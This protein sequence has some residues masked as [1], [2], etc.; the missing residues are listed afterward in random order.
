VSYPKGSAARAAE[1][2]K[3]QR[4]PVDPEAQAKEAERQAAITG[5]PTV[6]ANIAAARRQYA[7]N[8]VL[9]FQ[10]ALSDL[11]RQKLAASRGNFQAAANGYD[12]V[13]RLIQSLADDIERSTG[14]RPATPVYSPPVD[15]LEFVMEK[16]PS[17]GKV[18]TRPDG[19]QTTINPETSYRETGGRGPSGK[20]VSIP[21]PGSAADN[22][23]METQMKAAKK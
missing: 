12:R 14:E 18:V 4:V 9:R 5:N 16:K 2:M 21:V 20:G 11:R 17:T 23:W 3:N 19:S 1:Y 7:E 13:F 15:E 8:Q 6:R 10:G 22:G